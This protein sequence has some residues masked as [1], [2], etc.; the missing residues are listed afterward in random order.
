MEKPKKL[1]SRWEKL[2]Q[3]QA[4]ETM[5]WYQ[6]S[7]DSDFEKAFKEMGIKSGR[8]LDLGSG[9]GTQAMEL[10]RLGFTVTATDISL[11]AVGQ[12]KDRAIEQGL[13]VDFRQDDILKT[14]LTEKLDYILDRG[15]FHVI[16]PGSRAAYVETVHNLLE[17]GG[18]LFLKCFSYKQGGGD[19]PYRFTPEKIVSVFDER[20]AIISINETVFH[21]TL[22]VF[23]K[24]LFCMMRKK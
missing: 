1:P 6:K 13:R 9:P 24:A 8:V 7:L 4:V 18:F 22:P 21:G 15:C 11:S 3:S 10:A 23:P 14:K 12:A 2:Y 20:F 5:P 17:T 16:E 19:G